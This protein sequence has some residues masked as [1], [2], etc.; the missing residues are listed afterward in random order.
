MDQ[1]AFPGVVID[2]AAIKVA[3]VEQAKMTAGL[4]TNVS[5]QGARE[6]TK[7]AMANALRKRAEKICAAAVKAPSSVKHPTDRA[8]KPVRRMASELRLV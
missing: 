3:A 6:A 4:A 7:A 8:D 1:A 2:I 5:S